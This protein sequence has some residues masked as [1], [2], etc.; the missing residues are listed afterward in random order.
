MENVVVDVLLALG[1]AA[2]L[3]CVLGFALMRTV[4]DRLHYVGGSTAVGPFLILAALIVREGLS[5]ETADAIAA[6]ALL[7]LVNPTLVHAT[8]RAARRLEAR[9]DGDG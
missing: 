1:V 5:S 3:V 4:Y 9:Q 8:A 7:F 6:V 2:E